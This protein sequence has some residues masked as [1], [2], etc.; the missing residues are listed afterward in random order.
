[1]ERPVLLPDGHTYEQ[2]AIERWLKSGKK[3]SSHS[4]Q[5]KSAVVVSD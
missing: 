4:D 5:S 3:V 1:M 2:Y